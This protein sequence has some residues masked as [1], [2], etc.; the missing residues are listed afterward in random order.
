MGKQ[1]VLESVEVVGLAHKGLA[2]GKCNTGQV[3]FM[4]DAVPG[5]RVDVRLVRKKKGVWTGVPIHYHKYSPFRKDPKCKHFYD[6][7]G[8]KWQH[9]EYSEQLLHKEIIVR[10]ALQRI[11]KIDVKTFLPILGAPDPYFYRNKMEYSFSRLRWKT[12]AEIQTGRKLERAP[13]L[14]FHPPGFFDKV[15][16]IENCWL[17]NSHADAIRNFVRTYAL[18]NNYSFF[19]P[20]TH[21]GFLRNLIIRNSSIGEWMVSLVFHH[22][23]PPKIDAILAGLANEF[24]DL[25]SVQYVINTKK[26]DSLFDQKFHL[27]HGKDHIVEKLGK[28]KFRIGPKSF[29]QTNS[30]QAERLYEIAKAY[31]N[32]TGEE[33]L[34]DLY[35]GIGSIAMFVADQCKAVIGIEEIEAAVQDAKINARLN[36]LRNI[37]FYCGDVRQVLADELFERHGHPDVIITDPPRGGMHENVVKHISKCHPLRVVYISCNPAT[38]ARD[39]AMMADQYT[40]DKIQPVDMFPHTSHIENVALLIRR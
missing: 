9:F 4:S 15:V 22:D 30:K 16:D 18:E 36:E 28:L 31:C 2:I 10:D 6:C 8:C 35:S 13:A 19:N 32:L 1:K 14:G 27:Y 3:V 40:V 37:S 25:N 26:N 29:F 7:G 21:E 11:A 5:D 24:D 20:Q 33:V 23:D 38:Q 39:L 12:Q 17:Q 34:Y